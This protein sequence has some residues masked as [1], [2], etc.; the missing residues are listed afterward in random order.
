M[1]SAA[2]L[3]SPKTAPSSQPADLW[4]RR[5][6]LFSDM[7]GERFRPSK[8][9]CRI[10]NDIEE[11]LI[12]QGWQIGDIRGSEHELARRFG[13]CRVVVREAVRIL[14]ARGTARMRRG[15]NGGLL[16]Q[17]PEKHHVLGMAIRYA[18]LLACTASQIADARRLLSSVRRNLA[19]DAA[20]SGANPIGEA[21][22]WA[23]RD[24]LSF[25]DTIVEAAEAAC[26]P[27]AVAPSIRARLRTRATHVAHRIMEDHQGAQWQEGC[28][29]GAELDLCERYSVDRCVLRQAVRILESEGAVVSR[30]GRGHGLLLTRPGPGAICR[31]AQCYFASCDLTPAAVYSLFGYVSSVATALA[32]ERASP[33]DA[34][35]MDKAVTAFRNATS[36]H[37]QAELIFEVEESQFAILRNPL[38]NLFLRSAKAFPC[39]NG[40]AG[41][42]R[43]PD[44]TLYIDLTT[45]VMS[46][47]ARNDPQGAA[48]AQY[49]KFLR[50]NARGG[51]GMS[52]AG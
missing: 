3:A 1:G 27:C 4:T 50:M 46:A 10:A 45:A 11:D 33:A 37:E 16:V 28:K 7:V 18:R 38:I 49:E 12:I 21:A 23:A 40:S 31:L 14:E 42:D 43:Q 19:Q 51:E 6:D 8:L 13:V 29:L 15:P 44:K 5:R 24:V 9:A 17:K 52:V 35:R 30:A 20:H 22:N 32:A 41:L 39:W 47:I 2:L 34:A 48:S 25:F 36:A 26:A